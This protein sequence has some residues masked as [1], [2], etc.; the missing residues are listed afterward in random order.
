V[1][2]AAKLENGVASVAASPPA[3]VR[4]SIL[5]RLSHSAQD[6]GH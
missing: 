4:R 6:C 1:M 5:I 3:N 2:L